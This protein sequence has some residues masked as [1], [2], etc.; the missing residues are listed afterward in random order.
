MTKSGGIRTIGPEIDM[1]YTITVLVNKHTPYIHRQ[2]PDWLTA[3]TWNW[4]NP[5]RRR[6]NTGVG[7]QE[8]KRGQESW[9]FIVWQLFFFFPYK[10]HST[11]SNEKNSI[12]KSIPP[13]CPNSSEL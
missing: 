6:I 12:T 5:S 2:N 13:P 4:V 9:V 3:Y 11:F 1:L 8:P 7:D 10:A